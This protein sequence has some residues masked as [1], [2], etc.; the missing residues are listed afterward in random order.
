MKTHRFSPRARVRPALLLA[1]AA[2]TALAVVAA[3]S[4]AAARPK[5]ATAGPLVAF[6]LPENVTA[7]WEGFDKPIFIAAMKKAI[8]GVRVDVVNALGDPAKQQAQAEAELTK[9]AKVLV[10][11]AVDGKAFGVTA[12]K[13]A[14]QGVKVIAYDRLISGAKIDAY[15]SFDSVA[16][17]RNMGQWLAAHTKK[18]DHI[19][20]INGDFADQ[21]AHYV[22]QGYQ[23]VLNPL[24]KSGARVLVGPA[25]GTWTKGWQPTVAQSEMEQLLTKSKNDIQGVLSSNDG[26]AGGA[27]AALKAVGLKLPITGQDASLEGVQR[28]ILGT[29]GMTVFKDFRLQAPD[30]VKIV[31]AML[32]GQ[33]TLPGINGK[34]NNG[35]GSV[36]SVLLRVVAI[37]KSNVATLVTN[38][39][40]KD[41]LGGL[42]KVCKGLPKVSICK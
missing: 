8:P 31:A 24:F 15:V 22:Q 10:V 5:T 32:K 16:V 3:A 9:G 6:L 14:S 2:A 36:P 37:D 41:T 12:K 33:S 18:G 39:W 28:V 1:L 42:G 25:A 7:R 19:A 21:N 26:M 29:Q 20:L 38:G 4:S 11:S 40:V 23:S 34:V 27:A 13:A 30:T 17:G 35:A